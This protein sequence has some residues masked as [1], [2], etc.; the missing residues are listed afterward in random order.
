[1][2]PEDALGHAILIGPRTHL[3]DTCSFTV[4]S[5]QFYRCCALARICGV[6]DHESNSSINFRTEHDA[7]AFAS[8][9]EFIGFSC[10]VD[11]TRVCVLN[12]VTVFCAENIDMVHMV[13][14]MTR[15]GL[16][17][18]HEA[19]HVITE[20]CASSMSRCGVD[21]LDGS[22]IIVSCPSAGLVSA[23]EHV[24][25]CHEFQHKRDALIMDMHTYAT[26]FG[27]RYDTIAGLQLDSTRSGRVGVHVPCRVLKV[28]NVT[29]VSDELC[30][31]GHVACVDLET[32]ARVGVLA[33]TG[34]VCR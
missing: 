6:I 27:V 18:E 3:I 9:L 13:S 1:M 22:K 29:R 31:S 26:K 10:S 17:T 12:F 8:D 7:Y 32:G 33:H 23:L 16:V 15:D 28:C 34:V 25:Y 4:P 20:Y 5:L 14:K 24:L 11:N 21:M 30:S 2:R 19:G